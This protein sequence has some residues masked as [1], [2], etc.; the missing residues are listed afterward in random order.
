M[1]TSINKYLPECGCRLSLSWILQDVPF[2]KPYYTFLQY[3][4]ITHVRTQRISI[5]QSLWWWMKKKKCMFW[6]ETEPP[7][8]I[9]KRTCTEKWKNWNRNF[10]RGVWWRSNMAKLEVSWKSKNKSRNCYFFKMA[11]KSPVEKDWQA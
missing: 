1:A 10:F 7:T 2:K 4:Y 3:T 9:F 6:W 11:E 8:H 5:V